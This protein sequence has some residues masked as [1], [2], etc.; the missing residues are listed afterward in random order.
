M[1]HRAL[2]AGVTGIVGRHLAEHLNQIGGW[3]VIGVSRHPND[4]PAGAQ[5][6]RADL[7][8]RAGLTAALK[9]AAAN[10]VFI[11]TWSRQATEAENIRVNGAMVANLL[12]AVEAQPVKHVALV[13]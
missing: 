13:T 8:D 9:G 10:H 4:L 12:S 7:T 1:A 5:H 2:I 6:I 3:D 11:T